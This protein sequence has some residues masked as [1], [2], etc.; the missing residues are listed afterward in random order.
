MAADQEL[1]VPTTVS[2]DALAAALAALMPLGAGLAVLLGIAWLGPL[3]GV[4]GG[5]GVVWWGFWWHNRHQAFFPEDLRASSVGGV[6]ALVA[7]IAFL[8][9]ASL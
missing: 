9:G 2:Q 7:L 1:P 3:G 4:L 6:A 8:L 5:I